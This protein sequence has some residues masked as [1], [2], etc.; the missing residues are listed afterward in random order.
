MSWTRSKLDVG[1]PISPVFLLR[2]GRRKK[3]AMKLDSFRLDVRGWIRVFG[4]NMSDVAYTYS[5]MSKLRPSFP[6]CE[7]SRVV[8]SPVLRP[9]NSSFKDVHWKFYQKEI[10]VCVVR[11]YIEI[12]NIGA[13]YT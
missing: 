7:F 2:L 11:S 9:S 13:Y 5:S 1:S 12:A 3:C 8:E 4:E 10:N 6:V